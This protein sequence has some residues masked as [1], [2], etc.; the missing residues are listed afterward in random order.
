[1]LT[2]GAG[3][4]GAVN[5]QPQYHLPELRG[6][7]GGRITRMG[8]CAGKIKALWFTRLPIRLR[9]INE[10]ASKNSQGSEGKLP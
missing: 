6:K 2:Y 8:F 9:G 4:A 5:I 1:M 10:L 7:W 3:R